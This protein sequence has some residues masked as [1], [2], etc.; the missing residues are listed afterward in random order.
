MTDREAIKILARVLYVLV[1][2]LCPVPISAQTV[3]KWQDELR[4]IILEDPDGTQEEMEKS[5]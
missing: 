5:G 1:A 3:T 2:C 4:T